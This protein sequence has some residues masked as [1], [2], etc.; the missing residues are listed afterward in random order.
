MRTETEIRDR[1][2]QLEREIRDLQRR[3]P[4]A[5][6]AELL[7]LAMLKGVTHGAFRWVLGE[8][9][10]APGVFD[11]RAFPDEAK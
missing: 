6:S 9:E 5:K 8:K 3:D 2:A 4:D 10:V 1:M 7:N 11:A